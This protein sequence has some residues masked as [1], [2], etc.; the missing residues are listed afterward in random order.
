MG[1]EEEPEVVALAIDSLTQTKATQLKVT[2]NKELEAAKASEFSVIRVDNQA[3]KTVKA[4]AFAS[5]DDKKTV[6]VDVY[7]SLTDGKEYKVTYTPAT[8][9]KL[10]KTITVTDGKVAKITMTPEVVTVKIP[11]ELKYQLYDANGVEI[12]D[13]KFADKA[14]NIEYSVV[15][16]TSATSYIDLGKLKLE[17]KDDT[18]TFTI[19]YHTYDWKDGVEVGAVEATHKVTAV[20]NTITVD[21]FQMGIAKATE[22]PNFDRDTLRDWL[23]LGDNRTAFFRIKDSNKVDVTATCGYTVESSDPSVLLAAGDVKDGA[24]LKTVKE[25]TAQLIIKNKTEVVKTMTV[26]VKPERKLSQA[27]LS[28]SSL[29]IVRGA[30]AN[31]VAADMIEVSVFD[32]YG[33]W[34]DQDLIVS[35]ASTQQHSID[36]SRTNYNKVQFFDGGSNLG[37]YTFT[38]TAQCSNGN[39][40]T[41][42]TKI[43]KTATVTVKAATGT[44]S[45]DLVAVVNNYGDA[46]DAAT[47]YDATGFNKTNKVD[48]TVNKNNRAGKTISINLVQKQNG[49]ITNGVPDVETTSL[50]AIVVEKVG[51]SVIAQ[52]GT[53]IRAAG[54]E[55]KTGAAI[56]DN[57]LNTV[58]NA[59]SG[60]GI[61]TLDIDVAKLAEDE[62]GTAR[63]A[64]DKPRFIKKLL[65]AGTYRVTYTFDPTPSNHKN[66]DAKTI[67]MT[68]EVADSQ[69]AVT[70]NVKNTTY[71]GSNI[72]AMFN[73]ND[74]VTFSYGGA[75]LVRD[76]VNYY[77]ASIDGSSSKRQNGLFV[78]G[79]ANVWV[80]LENF[81]DTTVTE[82]TW[83]LAEGVAV[84]KTFKTS[85]GGDWQ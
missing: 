39:D 67:S 58:Y 45:N 55:V 53:A 24:V 33:D 8:G 31:S 80:N 15:Y 47:R 2:F 50:T 29:S 56:A 66:G 77:M 72:G 64:A 62:N 37:N 14:N 17:N 41:K 32:Q 70:A 21:G 49:V 38:I 73:D 3:V 42:F 9:D 40:D 74:Y 34:Y 19:K 11:T 16:S 7:E 57:A 83:V 75:E 10:D 30:N 59:I 51:G 36:S 69:A 68:F 60:G 85:T 44:P 12:A 5:A 84:N 35:A 18:A 79:K 82:D 48:T 25:G 71:P 20:E 13:V 23:A 76:D 22:K 28:Q 65:G 43:E 54:K 81:G 78:V 61:D 1:K 52:T 27:N 6:T 4:A 63:S 26:T 46:S